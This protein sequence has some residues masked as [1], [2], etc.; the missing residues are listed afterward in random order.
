MDFIFLL[1]WGKGWGWLLDYITRFL[2][3]SSIVSQPTTR[4]Y[5]ILRRGC[6]LFT[7]LVRGVHIWCNLGKLKKKTLLQFTQGQFGRSN[8]GCIPKKYE[9]SYT[10]TFFSWWK[11]SH[12][13]KIWNEL[14]T[15]WKVLGI[16]FKKFAR[17]SKEI[18]LSSP[19]RDGEPKYLGFVF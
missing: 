6:N 17:I 18:K 12:Y 5:F 8:L 3:L 11:I 9:K 19:C 15:L 16:F 2:L 14:S 1:F 7:N 13:C 4:F 10:L